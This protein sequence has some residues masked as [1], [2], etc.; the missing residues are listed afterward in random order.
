MLFFKDDILYKNFFTPFEYRFKH[1]DHVDIIFPDTSLFTFFFTSF[2]FLK[3]LI[4]SLSS[5]SKLFKETISS[6][7]S[8]SSNFLTAFDNISFISSITSF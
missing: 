8:L 5:G 2:S 3:Y 4:F 7:I 6:L 1:S